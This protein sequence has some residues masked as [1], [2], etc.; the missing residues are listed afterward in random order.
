MKEY[1]AQQAFNDTEKLVEAYANGD[2]HGGNPMQHLERYAELYHKRKVKKLNKSCVSG[3]FS[4]A[5]VKKAFEVFQYRGFPH[6]YPTWE[7]WA[8]E[9]LR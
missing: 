4:L 7:E 9:N 3:M 1:T 6:N 8:K 2:L 5:I